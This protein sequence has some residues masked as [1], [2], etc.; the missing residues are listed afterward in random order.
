MIVGVALWAIPTIASAHGGN[1]DPNVVHAC[2]ANASLAVRIVGVNGSCISSPSSKAET[3]MHWNIQGPQGVP[4]INGTNGTNGA[5][6]TSGAN[7]TNGTNGTSVTIT[8]TL[9]P[10]DTNCPNGGVSLLDGSTA[11]TFYLCNGANGTATHAAPPCPFDVN[12]RYV[13]C[14]NGTVTDTVTGLIWLQQPDCLPAENWGNANI[15]ALTLTNGLCGLTDGSSAGDWRLP[16][17]DEW[18]TTIAQAVALGCYNASAPTLTN[19]AGTGCLIAG[20][21]VFGDVVSDFY[22]SSTAN[23]SVPTDAWSVSLV[24]SGVYGFDKGDMVL[25]VWPVRGGRR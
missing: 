24:N 16:T 6:G 18:T 13:E 15:L 7:G 19:H 10:G 9:L 22:W 2:V 11:N 3:A 14:G 8:G 20:P 17:R 25:R 21:S 4:G 1:N 23:A 5:N 12:M